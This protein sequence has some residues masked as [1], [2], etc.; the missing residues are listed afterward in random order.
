MEELLKRHGFIITDKKAH[1][2]KYQRGGIVLY[3]IP[4]V[5]YNLVVSPD[6][7]EFVKDYDYKKYHNSNLLDFPKTLNNGENE[8]N[9]GYKVDF[10]KTQDVDDFLNEYLNYKN[11]N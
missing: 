7:F 2:S 8:I 5:S 3:V 9:Y 6:D 4:L 11:C 1:A 10:I